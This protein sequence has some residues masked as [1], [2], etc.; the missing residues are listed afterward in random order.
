MTTKARVFMSGRSQAIRLPAKLRLD[1]DE[2]SIERI[3]DALW[4]QPT[5]KPAN[6]IAAWLR[7]FYAETEP[8]PAEFL[9]QRQ[10]LP[11]QERDW[12]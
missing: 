8:L 6:N 7:R 11:P 3:G 9:A 2:V 4:I 1:T 12:T 5:V 10:D